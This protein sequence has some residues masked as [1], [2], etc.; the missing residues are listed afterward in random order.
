MNLLPTRFRVR[1]SL[2]LTLLILHPRFRVR[3][4]LT[5]QIPFCGTQ[6]TMVYANIGQKAH[7]LNVKINQATLQHRLEFTMKALNRV[8]DRAIHHYSN[9]SYAMANLLTGNGSYIHHLRVL[10]TVLFV[11]WFHPKNAHFH[12]D[13]AIVTGSMLQLVLL[14][15]RTMHITP[16]VCSPTLHATR[17]LDD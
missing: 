10:F 9:G 1:P 14:N 16:S 15:T 17:Q 4:S 11:A 3:P 12:R 13:P 2:P 8:H 6:S 5:P 7:P